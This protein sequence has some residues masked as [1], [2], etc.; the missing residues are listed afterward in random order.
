MRRR[1]NYV[2]GVAARTLVVVSRRRTP[3]ASRFIVH[4]SVQGIS[5]G[6]FIK[7]IQ[8]LKTLR[9][10]VVIMLQFSRFEYVEK[11]DEKQMT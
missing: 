4:P 3:T 10:K 7:F 6:V 11:F 5:E 9:L 1:W 2:A 8:F